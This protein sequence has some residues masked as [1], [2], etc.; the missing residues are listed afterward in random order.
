MAVYLR[1]T[2]PGTRIKQISHPGPRGRGTMR[3]SNRNY[4]PYHPSDIGVEDITICGETETGR[5]ESGQLMVLS[6]GIMQTE[7]SRGAIMWCCKTK[8]SR[9]FRNCVLPTLPSVT[10]PRAHMRT[11]VVVLACEAI[12]H[13]WTARPSNPLSSKGEPPKRVPTGRTVSAIYE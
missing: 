5:F 3:M 9:S 8:K 2:F 11:V 7:C 4:G 1:S 6:R 10:Q 13:D 12:I